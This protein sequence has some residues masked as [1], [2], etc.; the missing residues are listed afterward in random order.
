MVMTVVTTL[1]VLQCGLDP[2]GQLVLVE[3]NMRPALGKPHERSWMVHS[4]GFPMGRWLVQV[5]D[6]SNGLGR[7]KCSW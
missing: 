4:E 6:K 1:V 5:A 7:W 3:I 2:G